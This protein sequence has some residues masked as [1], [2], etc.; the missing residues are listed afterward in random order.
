VGARIGCIIIGL[1]RPVNLFLA[2]FIAEKA[3]SGAVD[4]V[5]ILAG[6]SRWLVYDRLPVEVGCEVGQDFL[7]HALHY[8]SSGMFASA[9]AFL[10][11]TTA[12]SRHASFREFVQE[13]L[14]GG[15]FFL[16]YEE[17]RNVLTGIIYNS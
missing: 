12:K 17:S 8:F 14:S 11:K 16:F 2:S 9:C 7:P 1:P 5:E 6:T 15:A 4:Y 10:L 13:D 3:L